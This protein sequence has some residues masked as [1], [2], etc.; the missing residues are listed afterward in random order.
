MKN[1]SQANR[2]VIKIGSSIL[3]DEDEG[4]FKFEWLKSLIKD[5]KMLTD[6]GKEVIIVTS[7]AVALGKQYLELNREVIKLEE[8]QAAAACGQVE[9]IKH[10]QNLLS[11]HGIKAAQ[12]LLTLND[13]ENRRR[14]LNAKNTIETLI[15]N[16]V[17]P[18]INEN[19]TVATNEIR[20]GDNDRLAA[21]I[22]QITSADY[23]ILLS[24]VNGLYTKNPQLSDDAKH[25]AIVDSITPEI[26]DMAG[27]ALSSVGS[28]GM[29]TKIE[30]AKM[31]VS[32]GCNMYLTSGKI[33]NP[34][35]SLLDGSEK[36]TLFISNETPVSA[37]KLWFL[38]A[39]NITGEI[40]IDDGAVKA[41][42]GGSSLLPVG[43][44]DINGEFERGDVVSIKDCRMNEIARGLSAYDTEDARLIM[45]H[46]TS[47][48]E[49]ITGFSGRGELVH[50]NDL[51]LID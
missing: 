34:I 20:F 36:S 47:E 29:T 31:A 9:L 37:R 18:I 50:R 23:L 46:Q 17:V 12:I 44:V 49:L 30:A 10:Y 15:E 32:C 25:L 7:G 35:Q 33:D 26:E 8:K 28:G 21:R 6:L 5:V 27:G 11:T 40:I 42:I 51:A 14:Y 24:D 22:A 16:N 38:G 39:L 19:D 43:V 3:M 2:V 45:G 13:L 1:L 4:Y 41:L 48:I